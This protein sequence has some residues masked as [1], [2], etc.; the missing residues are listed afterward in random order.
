MHEMNRK[1]TAGAA[2]VWP[3]FRHQW[4]LC[5]KSWNLL[6]GRFYRCQLV[7]PS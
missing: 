1:W 4:T 2:M 3:V 5:N 7:S 6:A